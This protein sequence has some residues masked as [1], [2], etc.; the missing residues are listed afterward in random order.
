MGETFCRLYIVEFLDIVDIGQFAAAC[1]ITMPCP[2]HGIVY[3]VPAVTNSKTL[4]PKRRSFQI[5]CVL[6]ISYWLE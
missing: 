5:N 2:H 1:V 4:L 3:T 6:L